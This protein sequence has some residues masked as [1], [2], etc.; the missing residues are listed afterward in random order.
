MLQGSLLSTAF[1]HSQK[2]VKVLERFFLGNRNKD[3]INT[4]M[5]WYLVTVTRLEHT[6][7]RGLFQNTVCAYTIILY[8]I[9]ILATVYRPHY[10][11]V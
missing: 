11:I 6:V 4:T 2:G 10:S 5:K 8:Y 3:S 7:K 1:H 9:V